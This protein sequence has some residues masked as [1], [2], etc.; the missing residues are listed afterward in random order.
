M[1]EKP[2]LS[3]EKALAELNAIVKN[4][5][6]GSLNLEDALNMF[7][8]GVHL[9]KHCQQALTEAEQKITQ[10]TEDGSFAPLD[11]PTQVPDES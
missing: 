4:L 10:L 1:T 8:R 2:P 9:T 5:E 11:P 7:E 3:F 6:D